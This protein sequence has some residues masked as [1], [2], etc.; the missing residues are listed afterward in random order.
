MAQSGPQIVTALETQVFPSGETPSI[1]ALQGAVQ[2]AVQWQARN[3]M[4]QTIVLLVTDGF[5]T[6]CDDMTDASF[7]GAAAAGLASNPPVRT[8]VVGI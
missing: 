4:R 7:I 5:P 2:H 3:P 1:P 8:Y 6:M